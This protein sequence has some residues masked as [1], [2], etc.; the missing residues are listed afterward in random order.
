MSRRHLRI[1]LLAPILPLGACAVVPA[2]GYY[3]APYYGGGYAVAPPVVVPAPAIVVRPAPVLRP[4]SGVYRHD[5]GGHG[6]R[7]G[8]RWGG[9]R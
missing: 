4:W 1:L 6:W 2:G 5:H 7:R 8:G 3:D 9:H